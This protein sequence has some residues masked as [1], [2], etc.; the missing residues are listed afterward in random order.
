MQATN[1]VL[2][3]LVGTFKKVTGKISFKNVFI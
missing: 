2:N 1:I 3:F